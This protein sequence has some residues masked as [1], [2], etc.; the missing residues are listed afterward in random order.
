MLLSE[1]VCCTSVLNHFCILYAFVNCYTRLF[2]H[3]ISI[4]CCNFAYTL[5]SSRNQESRLSSP[6]QDTVKRRIVFAIINDQSIHISQVCRILHRMQP[7]PQHIRE[8]TSCLQLTSSIRTYWIGFMGSLLAVRYSC[9]LC[10]PV[11]HSA[12][13][14][15]EHCLRAK[16]NHDSTPGYALLARICWNAR[17]KSQKR[18]L[19]F[20]SGVGG[21]K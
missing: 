14:K 20:L 6:C 1:S 9:I 10:F 17:L 21:S 15:S 4:C 5:L 18:T 16:P 13:Q 11:L 8:R 7:A 2:G 19:L 12:A 3:N